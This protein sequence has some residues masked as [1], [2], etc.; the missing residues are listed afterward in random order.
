MNYD[1][2][3]YDP[4]AG[5]NGGCPVHGEDY[6]RECTVCGAEFCTACFPNSDVCEEC[7]EGADLDD[8]EGFGDGD[9]DELKIV[10][11]LAPDDPELDKETEAALESFG[12][13]DDEAAP[14]DDL[15]QKADTVARA[16]AEKAARTARKPASKP[17]AKPAAKKASKPKTPAKGKKAAPKAGR[18]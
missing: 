14:T 1:D 16:A 2:E 15:F 10:E 18:K 7:A 3:E 17:A 13:F 9:A 4:Y 11:E 12:D 5:F 8:E 6:M